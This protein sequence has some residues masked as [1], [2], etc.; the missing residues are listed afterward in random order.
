MIRILPRVAAAVIVA[1]I[2]LTAAA[3]SSGGSSDPTNTPVGTSNATSPVPS[4]SAAGKPTAAA[5]PTCDTLIPQTTVK[6][7]K[8]EGWDSQA[9]PFYVDATALDGGLQCTWGDTSVASDHVQIY[10][11]API[12][13]DQAATAKASLLASGW[14]QLP[15]SADGVYITAGPDM[16]MNPDDQGY[17]MTYLFGDGWVKVADTK[18]GLLLVSWPAS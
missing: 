3:C 11:W 18:Q 13:A 8:S 17:G 16:I 15:D 12:T 9:G 14:V 7:L 1:G 5:D 2:A 10:G 6:A 4:D